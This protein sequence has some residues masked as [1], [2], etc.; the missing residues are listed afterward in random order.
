MGV[1]IGRR[2]GPMSCLMLK[3]TPVGGRW[4][5]AERRIVPPMKGRELVSRGGMV[6]LSG[7]VGLVAVVRNAGWTA[8]GFG[9]L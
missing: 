6:S 5:G 9:M 2:D 1:G 3:F 7:F 8:V 4:M